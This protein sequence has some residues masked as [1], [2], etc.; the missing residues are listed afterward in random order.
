MSAILSLGVR[1]HRIRRDSIFEEAPHTVTPAE[2]SGHFRPR[3]TNLSRVWG[4]C[5]VSLLLGLP[6][7]HVPDLGATAAPALD[8][9]AAAPEGFTID[10]TA[11]EADVLQAVQ[12]VVED[13][14]IHGT[15][16]YEREPRL[17]G[18]AAEKSSSFFGEW[19]GEGHVFYKVRRNALAPRHFKNSADI[20]V[21]TVRY[22]VRGV[23]E[24]RT[25]LQITA[26]FVEDGTKHVHVSDTSVETSE[27]AEIQSHLVTIQREEQQEAEILQ[28]RQLDDEAARISKERNEEAARVQIV[29]SSLNGLEQRANQLQHLLEVRVIN[30]STDLKS[31]PF[32]SATSVGTLTAG[33]DV[34]V[35]IITEYWY[36]VETTDGHRGWLRRDQVEP[37]P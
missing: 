28:K 12:S 9:S 14:Q 13:Q 36:G 5:L 30:P 10:L 26:V 23:L 8:K 11:S 19:G 3:T 37:L 29:D 2:R 25:H 16:I 7:V 32:H 34:L 31:A 20:G 35:E 17:T 27:F 6:F 22:V 1:S 15:L 24:N 18:A 21:I 4:A 33:S